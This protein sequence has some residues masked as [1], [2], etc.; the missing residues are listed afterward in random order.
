MAFSMV[1][2]SRAIERESLTP[3]IHLALIDA[4]LD[5]HELADF[6]LHQKLDKIVSGN[7]WILRTVGAGFVSFAVLTA[8]TLLL[9]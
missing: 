9:R 7:T 2:T 5:A 3:A 8:G 6:E 4:D 1:R